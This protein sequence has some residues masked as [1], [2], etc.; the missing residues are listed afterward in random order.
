VTL[1][2]LD[3][4]V[5]VCVGCGGV[6]KT[7][8]AAAI[9]LEAARQGR[10][11][12]V[13][14]I[15]PA[16]R[17]ADALG[18]EALGNQPEPLP[19]E[20]LGALG[21]PAQG[22]LSA[23][24]LDMKRTFDDLVERFAESP[25]ARD[26]VLANP[27]YRHVSDALAGSIEYSA[28]E[29]VYELSRSEEFDTLVVDTPPS[30]HALDFLD[31]PGRLLEFLDSRLVQIW[32]HPA[33]AAGR[34]GFRWFQWGTR[35]ALA[36]IERITGIG[37]LEDVSEFLLAFEHMSE[38]FRERAHRVRALLLG[39]E[40]AFVLVAGPESESVKQAQRFLE[41]LQEG[42]VRVAGVVA[43]RVRL[44][45]DPDSPPSADAT[46]EDLAALA[47][48][49]Q[50]QEGEGFPAQRAARAAVDAASRYAG[51]VRR[52]AEALLALRGNAQQRGSFFRVVPEQRADV[53]DLTGLARVAAALSADAQGR[54]P[55]SFDGESVERRG[56]PAT[57][58]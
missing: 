40:T 22:A 36:L 29:K 19:R 55:E 49:L 7:T 34:L 32:I 25:E 21:V 54:D 3:R 56:E 48:A 46:D 13:L 43:N 5:V 18:V 10:R 11:A 9:A 41:R 35:R 52:D 15:D 44:W 42:D 6:G 8:V 50:R 51:L 24:M 1:P 53:H 2:A 33:M 26:R 38:G 47:S 12:L 37:F 39:P 28:M 16:R 14:T 45:P 23:L 27:I 4:R 57:G 20:V 58:Q 31:A 30:Q 17:L